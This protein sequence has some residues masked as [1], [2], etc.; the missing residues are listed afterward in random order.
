MSCSI[1]FI[2]CLLTNAIC[3]SI[4][5]DITTSTQ[6]L[7]ANIIFNTLS[8]DDEKSLNIQTFLSSHSDSLEP[9]LRDFLSA[10]HRGLSGD[11]EGSRRYRKSHQSQNLRQVKAPPRKMTK[12]MMIRSLRKIVAAKIAK[13]T[14]LARLKHSGRFQQLTNGIWFSELYFNIYCFIS[15]WIKVILRIRW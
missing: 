15:Y 7:P 9:G 8:S 4:Q 3:R 12:Q 2:L 1:V 13:Q 14:I 6:P 10:Y 5:Q 11:G